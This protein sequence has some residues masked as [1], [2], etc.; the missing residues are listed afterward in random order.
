MKTVNSREARSNWRAL[1]DEVQAEKT[2]I[3]IERYGKPIGMLVPYS[4]KVVPQNRRQKTLRESPPAY[5]A[6][7]TE[8]AQE[9]KRSGLLAAL[10]AMPVETLETAVELL[11]LLQRASQNPFEVN[12]IKPARAVKWQEV[13][14]EGVEGNALKDSE[15]L[16]E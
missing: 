13:I 15:A 12:P 7:P 1:L 8:A 9:S 6:A 14:D 11:Q 5:E 2:T 10:Q 4:E 3:I 16:Y